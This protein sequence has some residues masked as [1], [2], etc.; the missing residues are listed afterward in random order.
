VVTSATLSALGR[1]DRFMMRAGTSAS[2]HYN[3]M[4]SPFDFS[5][6]TLQV[7][8][9]AVEANKAADHTE[10]MIQYLPDI[11]QINEG[12]LVLFA[13]RKQ[14]LDVF[15]GLPSIWQNVI[16]MQGDHS[17]QAMLVEHKKAIDAEKTSVLFGLASFSEGVDLPGDY[18][19]HVVIAKIPFS[20][21]DDPVEASLA[22]WVESRGGNAFMEISV[23]DASIKLVQS[24]GRLLR[25][26]SDSGLITIFDKRLITKRY[27][28][29]L[30]NALPPYHLQV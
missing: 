1:F 6:A 4:P 12:S 15:N 29:A 11:L 17:K 9:M 2:H 14:M 7:P 23:P 18:C 28:K 25:S 19:R 22:E 16:L 13:S 24:C 30:I 27:G 21:P 8:S 26:E 3:V 5:R 10:S 20:V